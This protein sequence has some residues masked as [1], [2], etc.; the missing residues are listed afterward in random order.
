MNFHVDGQRLRF[1]I[2]KQDLESLCAG[3]VVGQRTYLPNGSI[4]EVN[5][6]M[7]VLNTPLFLSFNEGVVA[8][9]VS[10]DAVTALRDVLPCREGLKATQGV[11]REHSLQL[12]L[13]VDIRTH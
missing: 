11:D 10:K 6:I 4:L 2:S 13:E 5:I 3:K 12:L 1:R 8:L 7:K 9:Q